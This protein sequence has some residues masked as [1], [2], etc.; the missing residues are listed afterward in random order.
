MTVRTILLLPAAAFVAGCMV[1]PDYLRP[2]APTPA[3]YKE[4]EGWKR[5]EPRDA[6]ARGKWWE[7]FGDRELDALAARVEVSNQNIQLAAAQFR[8]AQALTEQAR[9]GLFPTVSAGTSVIRS[10]SPSLFLL[11]DRSRSPTRS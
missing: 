9:A 10:K 3:A 2:S 5:A 11:C 8:V 7:M 4:M 6:L 1:G